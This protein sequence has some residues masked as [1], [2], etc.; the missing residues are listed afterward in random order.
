MSEFSCDNDDT[1]VIGYMTNMNKLQERHWDGLLKLCGATA[2]HKTSQDNGND[3]KDYD[4][5]ILEEN[6]NKLFTPSPM[7]PQLLE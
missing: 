7:K 2:K 5:S 1:K 3:S 4:I 6:H